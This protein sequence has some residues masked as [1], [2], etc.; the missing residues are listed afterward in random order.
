MKKQILLWPLLFLLTHSHAQKGWSGV[1]QAS[2]KNQ[3]HWYWTSWSGLKDK[4]KEIRSQGYRLTD[5]ESLQ[6][7]GQRK[8]YA[9]WTKDHSEVRYLYKTVGYTNFLNKKKELQGSKTLIDVESYH[10]GSQQYFMGIWKSGTKNH[11]LWRLSSHIK[12]TE[13]MVQL[14]A[15][16]LH[17]VD[18]ETYLENGQQKYLALFTQTTGSKNRLYQFTSFTK[19]KSKRDQLI[20]QGWRPSDFERKSING[21]TYY[22]CIFEKKTGA[23]SMRSNVDFLSFRAN[24]KQKSSE[25]VELVDFEV[26]NTN[27]AVYSPPNKYTYKIQET[28]DLCQNDDAFPESA[29]T[30]DYC[31]P[32]ATSN[33]FVWLDKNNYPK[34]NPYANSKSGQIKMVLD[35]AKPKYMNTEEG[36]GTGPSKMISGIKKYLQDKGYSPKSIEMA[37]WKN[38]SDKIGSK[39]KMDWIKKGILEH[40]MV[41]LNVGWYEYDANKNKYTRVGGHWVTAIGYGVDQNGNERSNYIIVHD[42]AGRAGKNKS[43]QYV[44][45]NKIANANLDTKRSSGPTNASGYYRAS[46]TLKIKSIADRSIL[47]NVVIVRMK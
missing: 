36:S 25:N 7:N 44:K 9:T 31:G 26:H 40:S 13:K 14:Q 18:V 41:F 15:K 42:P 47:D 22:L 43:Q 1:W 33:A 32:V 24:R 5:I 17:I 6:V 37:G 34:I 20:A 23:W 29:G 16:G 4:D 3:Y 45:L 10:E 21:K 38:S 11:E 8:Y 19:F 39:P 28:P 30:S 35:L 2:S 46:G 12:L 27:S